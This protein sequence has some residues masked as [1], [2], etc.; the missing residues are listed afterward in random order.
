M[1]FQMAEVAVPRILFREII[2]RIRQL[3]VLAIPARAG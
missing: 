2:D 3:R 1:I